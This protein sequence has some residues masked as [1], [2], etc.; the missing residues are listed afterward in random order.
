MGHLPTYHSAKGFVNMKKNVQDHQWRYIGSSSMYQVRKCN[1]EGKEFI[2]MDTG[3]VFSPRP[4]DVVLVNDKRAFKTVQYLFI[5]KEHGFKRLEGAHTTKK[6]T[7][8]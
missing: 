1:K 3:V 7:H 5:E 2:K 6:E 4:Y 8:K